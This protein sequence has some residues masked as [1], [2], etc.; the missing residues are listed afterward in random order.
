MMKPDSEI[1]KM[2]NF[3]APPALE[4]GHQCK[5]CNR[6]FVNKVGLDTHTRHVHYVH[7]EDK[8]WKIQIGHFKVDLKDFHV[9][10]DGK[11]FISC[12]KINCEALLKTS[13][14]IKEHIEKDH[15]GK[16]YTCEKC[17]ADFQLKDN[18]YKHAKSAHGVNLEKNQKCFICDHVT[19]GPKLL[20]LHIAKVHEGKKPF[21]CEKCDKGFSK[22]FNLK[23]HVQSV[24]EGR[25]L[26][27]ETCGKGFV[28]RDSLRNHIDHIHN[29]FKRKSQ[30][31]CN[32]CGKDYS[33]K[34]AL[35]QHMGSIHNE[36]KLD[37]KYK[38]DHCNYACVL[39]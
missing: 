4:K 12:F 10:Q 32:I 34:W 24:H 16:P 6:K 27:C 8:K 36:G 28:N 5:I 30:H 38:C 20:E 23:E 29:K 1:M 22:K 26:L 11:K 21:S 2:S 37:K 9:V 39:R 18:L 33:K 25:K 7:D 19:T 15:N 17:L 14:K 3:E 31:L 13:E 35:D